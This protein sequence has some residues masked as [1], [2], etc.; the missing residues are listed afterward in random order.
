MRK[1]L[2]QIFSADPY[3]WD[4]IEQ[5]MIANH[6]LIKPSD[7]DFMVEGSWYERCI[8]RGY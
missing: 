1:Y 4:F 3:T 8:G 7:A 5:Y 6:T 2:S